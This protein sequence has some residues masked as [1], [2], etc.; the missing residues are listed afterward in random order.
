MTATV[1]IE[2]ARK[3]DVLRIPTAATRFRPTTRSLPRSSSRCRPRHGGAVRRPQCA[4]RTRRTGQVAA[5]PGA[6]LRPHRRP[7]HPP[8][9]GSHAAADAL[10]QQ[11]A[12]GTGAG[13]AE[14]RGGGNRAAPPVDAAARRWPSGRWRIGGPGGGGQGGFG[15]GGGGENMT[16]E[17]R[18]E[19]RKR[20]EERMAAM[21]PEER[22]AFQERMAARGGGGFGGGNQAQGGGRGRIRAAAAA[23][24]A[25]GSRSDSSRQTA[26]A[27][28]STSRR[29]AGPRGQ[30]AVDDE[31]R[32]D[33]RLAVRTAADGR[34]PRDGVALGQQAAEAGAAAPRH[35]PTAPTPKCSTATLRSWAP[36][37]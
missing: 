33:D 10:A 32:D 27:Q 15:G 28:A 4:R 31:R 23:D 20:M 34:D 11:Q 14:A 18:E 22:K 19:R 7:R 13:S 24:S 17:Q 6:R 12:R 26:N 1:T 5:A 30:H 25:A 37:S 16:P 2:I 36:K 9:R 8:V 29:P 3:N 21:T 35:H